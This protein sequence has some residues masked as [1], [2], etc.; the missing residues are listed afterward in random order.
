MSSTRFIE[1]RE[2][3]VKGIP[4]KQRRQNSLVDGRGIGVHPLT[5][6]QLRQ[7]IASNPAITIQE[8]SC[9]PNTPNT[10]VSCIGALVR[11]RDGKMQVIWMVK[12]DF[13]IL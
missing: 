7:K 9:V 6:R 12:D 8:V 4:L 11:R 10:I 13:V 2:L 1:L 5:P 3:E